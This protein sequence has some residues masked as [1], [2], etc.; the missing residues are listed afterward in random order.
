MAQPKYIREA[1]SFDNDT[2]VEMAVLVN[3]RRFHIDFRPADLREPGQSGPSKFETE[4]RSL[5]RDIDDGFLLDADSMDEPN[6]SGLDDCESDGS[7]MDSGDVEE[8]YEPTCDN[9]TCGEDPLETWILQPFLKQGIFIQFASPASKPPL[10]TLHDVIHKPTLSFTF[11]VDSNNR[12]REAQLVPVQI[13][14]TDLILAEYGRPKDVSPSHFWRELP[15]VKLTDVPLLDQTPSPSQNENFVIYQGKRCWFKPVSGSD[16]SYTAYEREIDMLRSIERAGLFRPGQRIRVP[17]LHALV[18]SPSEPSK[19]HGLILEAISDAGGSLWD[20]RKKAP[21][22]LRK[23]WYDDVAGML[24][25]LHSADIVWGD[26]KADN[27]LLDERDDIWLID[28]GG[29]YTCGWIDGDKMETEEG[30]MQGL[31][32]FRR[33]LKLDA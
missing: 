27:M 16:L 8:F 9:P 6:D 10:S 21:V 29:G 7:G 28:F 18:V 30:D 13:P 14:T 3:G 23:R 26:V 2:H 12:N 5:C 24:A 4:L 1:V 11:K 19:V 25:R 17:K 22:S 33:F 15:S 31:A 20:R 32:K